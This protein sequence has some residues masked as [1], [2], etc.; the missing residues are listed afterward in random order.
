MIYNVVVNP[1]DLLLL[2][3]VSTIHIF[4]FFFTR[5]VQKSCSYSSIFCC[6]LLH[7]F[8]IVVSTIHDPCTSDQTL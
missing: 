4:T 7:P 1:L 6:L 5:N 3:L 8:K 2:I